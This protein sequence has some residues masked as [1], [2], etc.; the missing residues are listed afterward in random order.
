MTSIK[1]SKCGAILKNVLYPHFMSDLKNSVGDN[2]FS[3]LIDESTDISINKYLGI[4]IIYHDEIRGQIVSTFLSLTKLEECNASGIVTALKETL[5]DFGLNIKNL[6]GLGTDNASVMV[7]VNNGV[8]EQMKVEV[9]NLVLVRCVCHSLQLAVSAAA[10]ET[11]PR[12]LDY[13]ISETYNWFSRSSLRQAAYQKI[14]NLI[15]ENHD[16]L[17]IVQSCQT[18]WLSIA[19]AVERIHDQWLELK[20]HFDIVRNKEK[21]FMAQM[22]YEMYNDGQNLAFVKFLLPVLKDIQRVNKAFESNESDPTKLLDDLLMVLKS[23]VN[24]VVLPT[25][26]VDP[27][28]G[29]ISEFLDPK[30]YLGYQFEKEIETL[31]QKGFSEVLEKN[32][33]ERCIKF[34]TVLIKEIRQRLPDNVKILQYM[35]L[36]SVKNALIVKG[37]LIPLMELLK[38]SPTEITVIDN[39]WKDLTLIKWEVGQTVTFWN[40]VF[41]YRDS[42]NS[43]P[44]KELARFA[45][46]VL[47]LPHSNAE[48]ERIFS[49][50]NLV[51]NK[52]RNRMQTN[53]M[54]AILGIGSGLK[55]HAKTCFNYEIPPDVLNMIGTKQTYITS[56]EGT[57]QAVH[58]ENEGQEEPESFEDHEDMLFFLI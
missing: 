38:V 52:I 21:C 7:G 57:S 13:I 28:E 6:K 20:T 29:N 56:T 35:S 30:P 2:A 22:L 43:N 27:L 58:E 54:N 50:M 24:K 17:K 18:R 33:R 31:K 14:H 40:E 23:L 16:P 4:A 44:F 55:R 51:K 25:A 53:M 19:T 45:I 9:P 3:L 48:V 5:H 36:L 34:I 41:K 26:K 46:S 39:Q 1:R 10:T 47:V 49:Q 12:N 42:S 15:N 8:Y 11:L 32:T 37:S